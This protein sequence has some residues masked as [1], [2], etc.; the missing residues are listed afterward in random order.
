MLLQFVDRE[1]ELRG[2]EDVWESDNAGLVMIYGRRRMGKTELVKRFM[3]EHGGFYFLARQQKPYMEL[4][5]FRERY[6][7]KYNIFLRGE[8]WE[9]IFRE[10]REKVT[11][12]QAIIIDEFPY[13]VVKDSAILSEFQY[14][15]DEIL[16]GSNIVLI[17]LG[18]YV[19]VM[20]HRV[21]GHDS[22]LYG[23]RTAQIELKPMHIRYLRNFLSNYGIEDTIRAFGAVDSIPYYMA[24]FSPDK[25]FWENI[26]MLSFRIFSNSFAI[27]S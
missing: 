26:V 10:I 15:W 1:K 9:E 22:P 21:M 20:E 27:R 18:S 11:D 6:A 23:R 16:S 24:R 7:R 17:L 3:E 19:S 14:I 25:V 13:W 12:R 2:L 4:G 5:R 8:T